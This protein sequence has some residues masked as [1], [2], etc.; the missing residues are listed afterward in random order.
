[1]SKHPFINCHFLVT[2]PSINL[3]IRH[4]ENERVTTG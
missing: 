2:M 4:P 1:M 3:F